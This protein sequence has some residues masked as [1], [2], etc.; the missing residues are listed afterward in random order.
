MP[1]KP[2]VV[3]LVAANGGNA[4][5][6]VALVPERPVAANCIWKMAASVNLT[7]AISQP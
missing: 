6:P 2:D 4:V 5:C 1:L 7:L 3:G